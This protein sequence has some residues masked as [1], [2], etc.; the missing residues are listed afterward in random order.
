[1]WQP[2]V[3]VATNVTKDKGESYSQVSGM[4]NCR[5]TALYSF[6]NNNYHKKCVTVYNDSYKE[7]EFASV[8]CKEEVSME[9]GFEEWVELRL[10]VIREMGK[11]EDRRNNGGREMDLSDL[12]PNVFRIDLFKH[13]CYHMYILSIIY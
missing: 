13:T 8:G 5:G 3:T 10:P 6:V 1:M 4:C 7:T 12:F 9:L 2:N 11:E